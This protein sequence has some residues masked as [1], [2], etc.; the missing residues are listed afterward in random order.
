MFQRHYFETIL[1]NGES[2]ESSKNT[3]LTATNEPPL[4]P[5][6]TK[7]LKEFPGYGTFTGIVK[8]FNGTY[9]QVHY[10]DDGDAEDLSTDELKALTVLSKP[11]TNRKVKKTK[12]G[13]A[14]VAIVPT[15]APNPDEP[16]AEPT[17]DGHVANDGTIVASAID[18]ATEATETAATTATDG[19]VEAVAEESALPSSPN[20]SFSE[21]KKE[22]QQQQQPA[23]R[24][25]IGTQFAKVFPG[26]G[27]FVGV[28]EGFDG[29]FYQVFYPGDGDREDLSEAELTRLKSL[30]L[31][32]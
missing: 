8:A 21:P 4:F 6:G 30:E 9:Y 23:P 31:L 1:N 5:V 13:K 32:Q 26:Y 19:Q 17:V 24:I 14:S 10:P 18:T 2:S 16:K 27:T 22:Q 11:K 12:T 20:T 7:F 3:P 15:I 28:V 25:A 29:T